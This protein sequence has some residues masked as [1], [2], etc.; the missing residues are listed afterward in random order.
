[1][2]ARH[3]DRAGQKLEEQQQHPKGSRYTMDAPKSRLGPH[4]HQRSLVLEYDCSAPSNTDC[5][6]AALELD[7]FVA[8]SVEAYINKE[9]ETGLHGNKLDA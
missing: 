3:A 1:M 8:E 7:Q 5:A 6:A 2:A 9:P 4:K